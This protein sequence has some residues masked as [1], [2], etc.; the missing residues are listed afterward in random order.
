MLLS[1]SF[2]SPSLFVCTIVLSSSSP[3]LH[4]LFSFCCLCFHLPFFPCRH[5]SRSCSASSPSSSS[6]SAA[7]LSFSSSSS[8]CSSFSSSCSTFLPVL[9][10]ILLVPTQLVAFFSLLF[11]LFLLFFSCLLLSFL[12]LLLILVRSDLQ[13]FASLMG[14]SLLAFLSESATARFCESFVCDVYG[15]I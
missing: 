12:L 6:S 4:F 15:A 13:G 1:I 2:S 3:L 8:P 7:A 5:H 11:L 10:L 9:A 14:V